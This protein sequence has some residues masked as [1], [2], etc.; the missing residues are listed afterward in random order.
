MCP[1]KT[2]DFNVTGSWTKR[3]GRE[4]EN[5]LESQSLKMFSVL[6]V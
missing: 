2:V 3:D 6:P 5:F 1:Q 4:K